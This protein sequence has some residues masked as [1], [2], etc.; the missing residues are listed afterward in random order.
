[1]APQSASYPQLGQ[2][3]PSGVSNF[4]S[5]FRSATRPYGL[6]M[7]GR[8]PRR[9]SLINRCVAWDLAEVEAWVEQRRRESIASVVAKS[10]LPTSACVA[11]ALS[12]RPAANKDNHRLSDA[13]RDGRLKRSVIPSGVYAQQAPIRDVGAAPRRRRSR[14][15]RWADSSG[16]NVPQP[17]RVRYSS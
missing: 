17:Y 10:P 12:K 2:R 11:R 16:L 5:S 6:E 15:L 4:A 13:A 9:F 3:A 1:M 7:Q 8:F 14:A